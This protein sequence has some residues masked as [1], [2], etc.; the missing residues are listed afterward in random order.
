MKPKLKKNSGTLLHPQAKA[1]PECG[2]R[3]SYPFKRSPYRKARDMLHLSDSR[4]HQTCYG[5]RVL[6]VALE[7]FVEP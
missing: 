1:A 4:A 6:H 2:N 7:S 5:V 3:G